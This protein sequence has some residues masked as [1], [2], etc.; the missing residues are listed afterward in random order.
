MRT[1]DIIKFCESYFLEN[2]EKRFVSVS[3][4]LPSPVSIERYEDGTYKDSQ[5]QTYL[6]SSNF[7]KGHIIIRLD[8]NLE[9]DIE[10]LPKVINIDR[11]ITIPTY[12]IRSERFSRLCNDVFFD[13]ITPLNRNTF[14]PLVG[15]VAVSNYDSQQ[16]IGG[17]Y[18]TLGCLALDNDTTPPSVV[19]LSNN[20]VYSHDMLLA[21]SRDPNG[22]YTDHYDDD[23]IQNAYAEINEDSENVF[24]APDFT[25]TDINGNTH[26]LYSDY[27]NQGKGVII[28]FFAT[29]CGP[30]WNYKQ[31]GALEDAYQI[32]G[33][34]GTD[35]ITVL[36][37]EASSTTTTDDLYNSN[38]GDW[39]AGVTHPIINANN[40]LITAYSEIIFGYPTIIYIC[41]I[42]GT[43]S[44][45][46]QPDI[47][48]IGT[49]LEGTSCTPL[50]FDGSNIGKF[51]KSWRL[52]P[53]TY[54]QFSN[55]NPGDIAVS[56]LYT[57]DNS[58][59]PIIYSGTQGSDIGENNSWYQLNLFDG[60]ENEINFNINE[61][62][63]KW[64]LGYEINNLISTN[65]DGTLS[66][67]HRLYTTG[68]RMGPWG[69]SNIHNNFGDSLLVPTEVGVQIGISYRSQGVQNAETI[70]NISNCVIFKATDDPVNY[71]S[72]CVPASLGGNSGSAIVA[73]FD[74]E[75]KI[76][77]ILFAGESTIGLYGI[78][79]R[80][81]EIASALNLSAF[82]SETTEFM[83]S[84][85]NQTE[86]IDLPEPF[87]N[88][89]YLEVDGKKYWQTGIVQ[90]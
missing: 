12:I 79:C 60:P 66:I 65:L 84:N 23:I 40:T 42:S 59:E 49:I 11:K 44:Y 20:H 19:S 15:G 63:L 48:Q 85:V 2:L 26:S 22:I 37:I 90:Y 9:Y 73:E 24:G 77:G 38:L 53:W 81:D 45:I 57:T 83:I 21:G 72:T 46:G 87:S 86:I 10:F 30:C 89:Q 64:A 52:R 70:C 62:P 13:D 80:I 27:I 34:N 3:Y 68:A 41:P 54:P 16:V 78:F 50:E 28:D 55:L 61:S 31:T 39:T 6:N 88:E 17:Y 76:V 33:P 74:G 32:Y 67:N 36:A 4:G 58:G 14:R 5:Y 7:N 82:T 43:W 35:Q 75:Y 69:V 1:E 71:I 29:W 56:T 47:D 18:G 25:A 51:K 8:P